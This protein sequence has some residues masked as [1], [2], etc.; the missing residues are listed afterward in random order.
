MIVKIINAAALIFVASPAFAASPTASPTA[1]HRNVQG[2]SLRQVFR[3]V[4]ERSSS[5]LTSIDACTVATN[6]DSRRTG[7]R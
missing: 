2:H 5:S 4:R 1:S 7:G 6:K 3:C